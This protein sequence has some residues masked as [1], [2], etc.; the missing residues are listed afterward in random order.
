MR[1]AVLSSKDAEEG[2]VEYRDAALFR[3]PGRPFVPAFEVHSG[4][5]DGAWYSPAC[6]GVGVP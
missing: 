3:I 1:G 2:V 5:S 4:M 6:Q